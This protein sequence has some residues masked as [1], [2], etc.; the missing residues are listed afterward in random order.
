MHVQVNASNEGID[1]LP[2][3]NDDTSYFDNRTSHDSTSDDNLHESNVAFDEN[4]LDKARA[5]WQIGDW[6]MLSALTIEDIQ[7]H[8]DKPKLALLA[9]MGNQQVGKTDHAKE[10]FRLSALWG[11]DKALIARVLIAGVHRNLGQATIASGKNNDQMKALQHFT[12][13]TSLGLTSGGMNA[14]DLSKS[15]LERA[16]GKLQKE[17]QSKKVAISSDTNKFI[18]VSAAVQELVHGCLSAVDIHEQVD[19]IQAKKLDNLSIDDQFTFYL[20][21]ADA[22]ASDYSDR[23][24]A[25]SY[26]Q[27]ARRRFQKLTPQNGAALVE[28]Y[29]TLGQDKL[30]VEV[31]TELTLKGIGPIALSADHQRIVQK[32]STQMHQQAGKSGEHG[33]DLLLSYLNKHLLQYKDFV[34]P[35]TPVIIEIG[36]TRE[37]VPGQGSTRKIAEFCLAHDLKFVTVDM[38]PHNTNTAQELFESMNAKQFTAITMKGEDYLRQTEGPFDFVFLDAYDFDHGGHSELRQGRY[39]KFLGSRIDEL[40]CHQMHLECAETVSEKLSEFGV[41]C[42]DDTWQEEGKWTS[43]GT[44]AMPYL[45]ERA[46]DLLEARNRAAIL[47][48]SV[49]K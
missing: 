49:L 34:K 32:A 8:P 7:H 12:C 43:K 26:L 23:M 35:R 28:R 1:D 38:D 25:V 19:K 48:R 27:Y 13:A 14:I 6:L 41:V 20:A 46:F 5:Q 3:R 9:A 22:I 16:K 18:K 31:L 47:R 24:T 37:D 45:L 39:E 42:V 36:T 17:L 11:C 30:A 21:L 33:H 2:T 29:I 10:L 40:Q 44:L 15:Y 4:L